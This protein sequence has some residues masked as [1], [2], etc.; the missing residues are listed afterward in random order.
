MKPW[1]SEMRLREEPTERLIDICRA[2]GATQ[3]LAG[4]G[5]SAYVDMDKFKASGIEVS[6]QEF[7]HPTYSQC[8][9]PFI[10]G[11]SAV[12][13]LLMCGSDSLARLRAARSE[14]AAVAGT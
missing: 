12:D 11:M 2:V 6:I 13:L 4:A 9:E 8:Y 5:A 3:Y 1:A 10:P 7:Q 14:S